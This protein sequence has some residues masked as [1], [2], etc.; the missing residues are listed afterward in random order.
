MALYESYDEM[1]E[2][3][4]RPEKDKDAKAE[5]V[6]LYD[7]FEEMKLCDYNR[8]VAGRMYNYRLLNIIQRQ[9]E[10]GGISRTE[11]LIDYETF[12]NYLK[13]V[14]HEWE[15]FNEKRTTEQERDTLKCKIRHAEFFL[16][17]LSRGVETGDSKA[18]R[19]INSFRLSDTVYY[20]GEFHSKTNVW[21]DLGAFFYNVIDIERCYSRVKD[22][23]KNCSNWRIGNPDTETT[24]P[25]ICPYGVN[26]NIGQ[27]QGKREADTT[28]STAGNRGPAYATPKSSMTYIN[29]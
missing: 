26:S 8:L 21:F 28:N 20:D 10:G 27:S 1:T 15:A 9:R 29:G 7:P 11:R 16:L 24:L 17:C 13:G 22:V 3:T 25:V 19:N 6:L 14:V 18:D 2:M 4:E 12:I 23:G 5:L